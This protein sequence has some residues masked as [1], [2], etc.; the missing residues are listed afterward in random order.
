MNE[1]ND[2]KFRRKDRLSRGEQMHGFNRHRQEVLGQSRFRV[3]ETGP[4]R[5]KLMP[6]DPESMKAP[7]R[8]TLQHRALTIH[9]FGHHS[10]V[11]RSDPGARKIRTIFSIFF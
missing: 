1:H 2:E 6:V 8:P 7:W 4:G 11:V 10:E 9:A 5:C 3:Q